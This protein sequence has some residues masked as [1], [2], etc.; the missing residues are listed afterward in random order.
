M[1]A[2]KKDVA[3][4]FIV[5][6]DDK[7][8]EL[9]EL[10][11]DFSQWRGVKKKSRAPLEAVDENSMASRRKS[12]KKKKKAPTSCPSKEECERGLASKE[13]IRVEATP[14]VDAPETLPE[15]RPETLRRSPPVESDPLAIFFVLPS[16]STPADATLRSIQ[17]KLAEWREKY[18]HHHLVSTVEDRQQ[19]ALCC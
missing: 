6:E 5:F 17:I 18:S 8:E 11:S 2:E 7:D 3:P 1:E 16:L 4:R 12:T 9:C 19:A 10:R 15:T 14:R 13:E